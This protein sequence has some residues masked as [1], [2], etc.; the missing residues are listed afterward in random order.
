MALA[1]RGSA[2]ATPA[3]SVNAPSSLREIPLLR[4]VYSTMSSNAT[5]SHIDVLPRLAEQFS[6]FREAGRFLRV[7]EAARLAHLARAAQERAE[8]RG[9]ER[10]A[11]AHAPHAEL[12]QLLEREALRL[13]AHQEVHG[14]VHR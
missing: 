4:K 12:R 11:D 10:A 5:S 13:R 2:K 1:T 9:R 7:S 6:D 14:P 3:P 8:R